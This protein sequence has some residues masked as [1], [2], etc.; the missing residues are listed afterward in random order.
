M[1]KSKNLQALEWL[2]NEKKKDE[3]AIKA[4]KEK[5]IHEVKGWNK[6]CMFPV[7]EKKKEKW[8]DKLKKIFGKK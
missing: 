5:T 1:K 3:A 6:E 4:N 2:D 8:A 7:V